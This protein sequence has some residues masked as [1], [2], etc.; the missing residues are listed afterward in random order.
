MLKL[1]PTLLERYLSAADK[2][3]RLAVGTDSPFVTIDSFRIPD[4]RSQERRLPDMPFGTRGGIR[5][6]YTF[7]QDAEYSF[8]AALAR[9]LNEGMPVYTEPQVLEISIDRERIATFTLDAAKRCRIEPEDAD[10]FGGR[11]NRRVAREEQ[12]AR[13]R[14]DED[15]AVRVPVTAGRHEVIVTFLDKAASV[16]AG[17]REPFGRPFPR[18]LNIPEGRLRLVPTPRRDRRA[19]RR[20][21]PGSDSEPRACLR[22]PACRATGRDRGGRELRENHTRQRRAPR[23]SAPG[24]RRRR[25][26]VRLVLSRRARRAR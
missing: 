12:Q 2:I 15:W 13:N 23:L 4:D 3:S 16:P 5:I 20:D 19:L 21:G 22:L 1:S 24:R 14:A 11:M 25:G 7:P 18:G 17:K 8:S 26:A 10:D 9:D 6:D